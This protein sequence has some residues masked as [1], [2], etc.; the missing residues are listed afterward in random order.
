MK[1]ARRIAAGITMALGVFFLLNVNSDIQLGFGLT[2][3]AV[4]FLGWE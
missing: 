4:G 2:L 1:I 3:L